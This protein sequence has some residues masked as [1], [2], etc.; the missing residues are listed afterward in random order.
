M[1]ASRACFPTVNQAPIDLP[2]QMLIIIVSRVRDVKP[3]TAEA[4]ARSLY[5]DV[6]HGIGSVSTLWRCLV[7][8]VLMGD[9][10]HWCARNIGP[11]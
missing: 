8:G 3:A 6:M 1:P 2:E 10:R 5:T 9:E 4:D 7:R 11:G